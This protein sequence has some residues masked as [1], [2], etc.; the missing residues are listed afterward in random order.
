MS[1]PLD[2]EAQIRAVQ[3][4]IAMR[5]FVYPRRVKDGRMKPE[6]AEHETAAMEAVLVT[7]E[8]VRDEQQAQGSLQI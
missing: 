5:L 8:K 3:R 1:I 7:L 2:I 4:E 6:Q